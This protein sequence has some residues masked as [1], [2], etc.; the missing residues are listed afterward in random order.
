MV[1]MSEDGVKLLSHLAAFAKGQATQDD[2]PECAVEVTVCACV[3]VCVCACACACARVRV[4]ACVPI[5]THTKENTS[6]I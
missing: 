3:R 6:E 5:T 2:C 1:S 4:C